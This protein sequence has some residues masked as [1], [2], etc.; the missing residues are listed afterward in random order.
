MFLH[1]SVYVCNGV[2]DDDFHPFQRVDFSDDGTID[3]VQLIGEKG[4]SMYWPT[5]YE[6]ESFT[7]LATTTTTTTTTTTKTTTTTLPPVN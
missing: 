5:L 3:Q 6:V 4:G 2:S 7:C 1:G